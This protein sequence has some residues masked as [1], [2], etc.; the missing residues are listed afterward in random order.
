MYVSLVTL[1]FAPVSISYIIDLL[2]FAPGLY[3][4]QSKHK[5][6]VGNGTP[7]RPSALS[8]FLRADGHTGQIGVAVEFK[9]PKICNDPYTDSQVGT[10][11]ASA[12]MHVAANSPATPDSSLILTLYY[13]DVLCRGERLTQ[14]ILL[15]NCNSTS[16]VNGTSNSERLRGLQTLCTH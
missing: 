12:E 3:T 13:A 16:K 1:R 9:F 15:R 7:W 5:P 8:A 11:N 6:D 4:S 10:A 2:Q 14:S